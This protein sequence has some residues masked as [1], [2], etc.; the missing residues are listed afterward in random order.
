MATAHLRAVLEGFD[1]AKRELSDVGKQVDD[2]GKKDIKVS[3][4]ANEGTT[5]VKALGEA[6]EL[7]AKQLAL[8]GGAAAAA[9]TAVLI[10]T[11]VFYDNLKATI[12][13][14]ARYDDLRQTTGLMVETIS[15][16]SLA[17][18]MSGMSV[19]QGARS[20]ERFNRRLYEA[21][22]GNKETARTFQ[23]LGI[24]AT[25]FG[26]DTEGAL[27]AVAERF[28]GMEDGA[29][30]TALAMELFGRAGA[31]MIPFLNEGA[32]GLARLR[33]EARLAGI[34]M[35]S[36]TAKAADELKDAQA[37]LNA[38]VR[39]FW[40][41]LSGPFIMS[42]AEIARSM[43]NAKNE[44]EGFFGVLQSGLVTMARLTIFGSEKGQLENVQQRLKEVRTS[45]GRHMATGDVGALRAAEAEEAS[46]VGDAQR[47]QAFLDPTL[48]SST[49][50]GPAP[51][52]PDKGAPAAAKKALDDYL[53]FER[54][55]QEGDA[56]AQ[57]ERQKSAEEWAKYQADAAK[58]EEKAG[59]DAL[60]NDLYILKRQEEARK[61]YSEQ[62][63]RDLK[64]WNKHHLDSANQEM[65]NIGRV[66]EMYRGD[67][68]RALQALEREYQML[69]PEGADALKKIQG[70]IGESTAENEQLISSVTTLKSSLGQLGFDSLSIIQGTMRGAQKE[71]SEVLKGHQSLGE[72]ARNI[73]RGIGNAAIDE[74]SRIIVNEGWKELIGF[75]K[76][77]GVN[78]S[79]I[80]SAFNGIVSNFDSVVGALSGGF[81]SLLNVGSSLIDSIGSVDWGGIF[82]GI[83]NFFGGGGGGGY[84]GGYD[85]D[86]GGGG[87]GSLASLGYNIFSGNWLGAA[88]SLF[89]GGDLL[90]D[91]FGGVG[92]FVSDIF[93]GFFA[94]GTDQMVSSPK[95]VMVGENG[96]ER[97]Q[98]TPMAGGG[99]GGGTIEARFYGPTL[100][101]NYGAAKMR[102][103][104]Q[105]LVR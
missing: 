72:A 76:G 99:I 30:K 22:N 45:I 20:V 98:V 101:D 59:Q 84:G 78:L 4:S 42:L 61:Q 18:E 86:G 38:N 88:G 56:E 104:L 82:S 35:S 90:G 6:S 68:L 39:G 31:Q 71:I 83:G 26:D 66:T 91:V 96:P 75:F 63:E 11:K 5:A 9:T 3:E 93:G 27:L 37:V 92:D 80:G 58:K 54:L 12:E 74:L 32:T 85:D 10:G 73:W 17:F 50:K 97:L 19:D 21:Q 87:L 2:L 100:I 53:Y 62:I 77:D 70:A 47:L 57:R 52:L 16:L 49:G 34:V 23:A 33:E 48:G 105:R 55:K 51:G 1:Q 46:L 29:G 95:L 94:T 40:Q 43:R 13:V 64:D 7:S 67:K 28:A 102:R 41:E 60:K 81:S 44:G 79:W 65:R 8:I 89:G 25:K 14:G 36:E 15:G 24:D 69:G 103:E